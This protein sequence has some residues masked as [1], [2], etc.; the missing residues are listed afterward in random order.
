MLTPQENAAN[1]A[2][3]N[4]NLQ[5]FINCSLIFNELEEK[6]G[7]TPPTSKENTQK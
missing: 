4:K 6:Q 2:E 3:I 7:E 5:D 1:Q